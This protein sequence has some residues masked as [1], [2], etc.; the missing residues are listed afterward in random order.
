MRA[1]T[2]QFKPPM[3][4]LRDKYYQE[5]RNFIAYPATL[6]Q[7]VGGYPDLYK[8]MPEKNAEYLNVV[9]ERAEGLFERLDQMTM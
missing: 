6:F 2:I 1:G 3:E 9:Y 5:I 4:E 8:M 7:G